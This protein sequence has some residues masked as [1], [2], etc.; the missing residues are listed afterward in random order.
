VVHDITE[1]TKT[2]AA[3]GQWDGRD[4]QVTFRPL[5][6]VPPDQPELGH[7]LPDAVT[8]ADPPVTIGRVAIFY[9]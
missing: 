7:A 6:L 2:L 4:V 9:D 3:Q 5:G 1:L 8:D